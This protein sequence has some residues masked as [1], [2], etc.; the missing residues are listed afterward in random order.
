MTLQRVKDEGHAVFTHGQY[1][2]NIVGV[3]SSP[4][5]VNTFD[6][7]LHLIYKGSNDEW[8]D[9]SVPCTTDPGLYWLQ[10]LMNV[11]GT[12]ILKAGQ[13]RG[14]YLIGKH[15]GLYPALVQ[16]RPVKCYRDRNRDAVLDF[17]VPVTE[18]LYGINIHHAG[19]DSKRVEKWSAGCTVVGSLLDWNII[20]SIIERS[21]AIYGDRFT[22]TL[23]EDT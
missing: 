12:A 4:G 9:I 11:G 6:D 19:Y 3:R 14:A 13:Y 2:L 18:G 23:I 20:W 22:Y 7:S 16:R 21:A 8:V 15:R 1:N 17:D 5:E 10:N